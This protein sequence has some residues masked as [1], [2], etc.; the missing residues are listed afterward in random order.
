MFLIKFMQL[1]DPSR[2]SWQVSFYLI[3]LYFLSFFLLLSFVVV[4]VVV[5]VLWRACYCCNKFRREE[6]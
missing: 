5:V 6:K 4:F 2:C 3:C 1:I